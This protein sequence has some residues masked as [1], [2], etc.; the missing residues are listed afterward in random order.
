[1]IKS[2]KFNQLLNVA[3]EQARM[4]PLS[5]K[6]GAI[7]FMG[8]K[9]YSRGFN[10]DDRNYASGQV[11]P[12]IHAEVDCVLKSVLNTPKG[13]KCRKKFRLMVVRINSNGIVDS[14]P[15]DCCLS[16][17]DKYPSIKNIVFSTAN[18]QLKSIRLGKDENYANL[19][20]HGF[21]LV[22]A[23]FEYS[24][25]KYNKSTL[26]MLRQLL[27]TGVHRVELTKR[28]QRSLVK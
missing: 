2:A 21:R 1:M 9:I 11:F 24:E 23:K 4:S 15:C 5:F 20:S 10:Y 16:F 18:G 22:F 26:I 27:P 14:R 19:Y 8:R 28:D 3:V 25:N 12:S 17:L 6:H 7:L 13:R